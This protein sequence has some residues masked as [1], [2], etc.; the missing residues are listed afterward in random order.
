MDSVLG[1]ENSCVVQGRKSLKFNRAF[2]HPAG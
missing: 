2:L 1:A